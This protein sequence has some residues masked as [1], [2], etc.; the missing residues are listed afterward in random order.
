MSKPL[1]K[2][3]GTGHL[4]SNGQIPQTTGKARARAIANALKST[5]FKRSK[6][7]VTDP[8]GRNKP[9]KTNGKDQS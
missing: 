4:S 1:R 2:P 5:Q 7:E 9:T 6:V 8:W 3:F